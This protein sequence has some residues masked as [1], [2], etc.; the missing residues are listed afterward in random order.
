[1]IIDNIEE[2]CW[3]MHDPERTVEA[4]MVK[5]ME[6]VGE[7]AECISKSKPTQEMIDECA[8]S[9]IVIVDM[10]HCAGIDDIQSALEEAVSRKLVR[11]QTKYGKLKENI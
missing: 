11:W 7:V 9:L 6:E 10:L 5:L 8:D 2:V 4:K 1:M 3:I